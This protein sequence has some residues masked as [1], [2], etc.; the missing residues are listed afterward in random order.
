VDVTPETLACYKGKLPDVL[1]GYWQ[2]YGFCRFNGGLMFIVNPEDYEPALEEWI[3]DTPIAKQDDYHV[4]TRTAFGELELW[5]QKREICI[6]YPR[7]WEALCSMMA[8]KKI[9]EKENKILPFKY[10]CHAEDLGPVI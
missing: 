6:K 3:G 7:R 9:L 2:E 8:T 1:L 10:S 4:V 5:G